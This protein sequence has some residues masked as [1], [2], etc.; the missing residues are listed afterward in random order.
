[1]RDLEARIDLVILDM[2]MPGMDGRET[3]RRLKQIDPDIKVLISSGYSIDEIASDMLVLG[4]GDFIQ[5]PF[6]MY[7]ASKMIRN[8]LDSNSAAASETEN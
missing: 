8:V 2:I 6:D 5:K 1:L 3:F 7:Q 4:C